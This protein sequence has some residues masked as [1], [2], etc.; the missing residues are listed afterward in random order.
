MVVRAGSLVLEK[1]FIQHGLHQLGDITIALEMQTI[2]F[3]MSD[4]TIGTA[5]Y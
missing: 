4:N 2:F 5:N 3:N 1:L